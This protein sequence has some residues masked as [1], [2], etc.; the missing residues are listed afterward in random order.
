[1]Y[2]FF[3]RGIDSVLTTSGWIEYKQISKGDY[4]LFAV[5]KKNKPTDVY[6]EFLKKYGKTSAKQ[7]VLLVEKNLCNKRPKKL[8]ISDTEA[9]V[10]RNG[11]LSLVAFL[12][13]HKK[14]C[15]QS[16]AVLF[17][18]TEK[19]LPKNT[20]N[21]SNQP[22]AEPLP[23]V[24]LSDIQ[25]M[26]APPLSKEESNILRIQ[27]EV[28]MENADFIMATL[29]TMENLKNIIIQ[30][31]EIQK[32]NEAL[33]KNIEGQI[34]DELHF[35]EFNE[36]DQ[37]QTLKFTEKLQNLRVQRR[38][39]KDDLFV[40]NLL[41]NQNYNHFFKDFPQIQSKI[42]HLTQRSYVVKAPENYEH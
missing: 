29:D 15:T 19:S 33:L 40:A 13:S 41:L 3:N 9:N 39:L 7:T 12:S 4:K 37:E 17:P 25:V 5:E 14:T 27:R 32:N 23:L 8:K 10:I 35:L 18:V 26:E 28:P 24:L 16:S 36:L 20:N 21:Q 6:Q 22:T 38:N 42:D 30:G 34:Q 1:M 2:Y 11:Y 31:Q